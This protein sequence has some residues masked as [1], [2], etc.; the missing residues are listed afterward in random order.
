L[1]KSIV[2]D[3]CATLRTY[4]KASTDMEPGQVIYLAPA[5]GQGAGRGR[6]IAKTKLV[7]VTL[8]VMAPE[9]IEPIDTGWEREHVAR[10]ASDGFATRPFGRGALLSQRDVSLVAGFSD[11]AVSDTAVELR[12]RGEF[13]PLRGYIEDMGC[14]PSHKAAIVR[15]YPQGMLT[16]DIARRTFHSKE[17]V[18]RYIRGFERVRLLASKFALEELPLL[19]GMSASLV[20]QYLGLVEEHDALAKK[21]SAGAAAS[22]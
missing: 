9:D 12:Q 20:E 17:A 11:G 4:F 22:S 13:L 7:A 19:T 15:L 5:K 2:D 10:S 18:D 21:V 1:F 3:I 6:T 14:F 8:T 16:P